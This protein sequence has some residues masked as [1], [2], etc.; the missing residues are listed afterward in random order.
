MQM[1]KKYW[2][3]MLDGDSADFR[4][5][6]N[7]YINLKDFRFGPTSDQG[8]AEQLE[9]VGGTQL[10]A[11]ANLPVGGT[12]YCIG[13]AEDY[14]NRRIV[15]FLWNSLGNHGIYCYDYVAAI[16]NPVLLSSQITGGLNFDKHHLIHSARVANNNVYWTDNVN[17]PRR[18]NID[19]GIN[20]N[21][22]VIPPVIGTYNLY[23][24]VP[25]GQN[26]SLGTLTVQ[27]YL[28]LPVNITY[29]PGVFAQ[30]TRVASFTTVFQ[31]NPNWSSFPGTP[32]QT[33]I[34][35]ALE[36]FL[37]GIAASSPATWILSI[38][39]TVISLTVSEGWDMGTGDFSLPSSMPLELYTL[40]NLYS[41]IPPVYMAPLDQ[42][43]IAWIRRQ[44]AQPPTQLKI[45]ESPVPSVNF[46]ADEAFEFAYR[47]QYIDSELSTLSGLS[48]LAD[49]N[50]QDPPPSITNLAVPNTSLTTAGY[51]A[52]NYILPTAPVPGYGPGVQAQLTRVGTAGP[53]A[54][55]TNIPIPLDWTNYPATQSYTSVIVNGL[56]NYF[57]A[58]PG[59]GSAGVLS[60]GPL[61]QSVP[62]SGK[63]YI[64]YRD[65]QHPTLNILQTWDWGLSDGAFP[66]T[67]TAELTLYISTPAP[68]KQFNRI[69]IS[70]PPTETIRQDVVQVDLVANFLVSGIYF[71][72]KSW[73][74]SLVADAIAIAYHNQGTTP[75]TY[76]FYNN[77]AGIA[78][79]STYAVKPYDSVPLV[80]STIEIAKSRG[81]LANYLAGYTTSNLTTSLRTAL[82][83]TVLGTPLGN[84]IQGEWFSVISYFGAG[85]QNIF[86]VIRT[87][88]AVELQPSSPSGYYYYTLLPVG[89]VPPFPV[90]ISTG[91]QYIG[92]DIFQTYTFFGQT[93]LFLWKPGPITD[94]G[95]S[96]AV[97]SL[98]QTLDFGVLS[99]AFKSNASYQLGVT[100]YD[101]YGRKGGIITNSTLLVNVPNTAFSANQY[102]TVLTWT[103]SNT[104]AATEIP[105]WAYYYSVDITKCLRTRFFVQS[106][107]FIIYAGKD[108]ENDYTFD[109]EIW[110]TDLAGVAI[111]LTFL[112]S[113]GMGYVFSKGDVVDFYL[114]GAYYS[115]SIIGQSA[116]YII[117]E[118]ADVGVLGSGAFGYY[119]I[120]TPYQPQTDEPY[121]EM[122]AIYPI[123]NPTTGSPTYGLLS[124]SMGGDVFVSQLQNAL[125]NYT[126]E[127]MSP[128]AKFYQ[129]WFTDAGRPNF[130]DYIGQVQRSTSVVWSD[131]YING[132]A[133]NGLSTFEAL[134]QMDLDPALGPVNKL[135]LTSKTSKIGVV[136]LAIC[137]GGSTAS[138]Y[139]S[140]NTLISDT[141]DSVVA[142]ANSV[143][144]SVHELKGDFGT[145]NP[146]SV[147]ELRGNVYW[148][149][150]QNGKIIQYADNG[151][152]PISNYKLSRFWKLFSDQYKS[153][154]VAEI[155]A[156][157]S[158]PYV[159][160]TADPHHGELM[161]SVPTVL[162]APPNGYLPD[163]PGTPYPFDIYDG[164]G[165]TII[166]KLYTDPNHWQGSYS[167]RPEYLCYLE[168]NVFSFVGG[169]L[170]LHNQPNYCNYY[171][172]QYSPSVMF[173]SNQEPSK[174]KSY[175]NFSAES[176]QLPA[177]IY[178]MTR[179][180]NLQSS[181]LY[182]IDFTTLEGLFYAPIYRN[183][184]DP[185]YLMDFPAAL[186][187]GEKMRG[188]ALY[189]WAQWAITNG[190][191]QV[192]YCNLGYTLSLGQKV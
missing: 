123:V 111:D 138:I 18:L 104:S 106:I 35:N 23:T 121:F 175:N 185:A 110:N 165:K 57:K 71:I 122:G 49:F 29:G 142:Q 107:G 172:V 14:P 125:N 55:A 103:L 87:T 65:G 82:T 33:I 116:Q 32:Y 97:L 90:S 171:G 50:E 137:G 102:A 190:I 69:D 108:S 53:N 2:T 13:T 68:S 179:Y 170:Y 124:G 115:L 109:T 7:A 163:Y 180:P 99:K 44:P 52:T 19:A 147:I 186:I 176:N 144:G 162:A 101:F 67:V 94:T 60:S 22:G 39:G 41:T 74:K 27:Y 149:D 168:D 150:A 95:Q 51:L 38:S 182:N 148:Y 62:Q 66:P 129:S 158:R 64:S 160:G 184:L 63:W 118:L 177:L 78:L 173:L 61:P 192:K 140:E 59:N 26:V 17:E 28:P 189:V 100:F 48:T 77:Q 178:L 188:T 6:Q 40:E 117:A 24:L 120:Y 128:N 70:I 183:K 83:M 159:F 139:L 45:M 127:S 25:Y 143:I 130:L 135:Q 75:L 12:T 164:I 34:F 72:I 80:A 30:L 96:S 43:I 81:F 98:N 88:R 31:L 141:G 10:I 79:D 16:I 155:E 3:D 152:F 56:N 86:Y 76:S 146:E 151:L 84:T 11:N 112:N 93:Q 161:W 133:D 1:E 174:P 47:Y 154:T 21:T 37:N 167:F 15:F 113:Q 9:S 54:V 126:A 85:E 119:E 181:D 145:L 105:A 58:L 8:F 131:T 153:L 46:I 42:S 132:T 136:M 89:T 4:V 157:G 5:M 187:A 156:L 92:T 91:L 169:N 36:S 134:D 166:Y 73:R 20:M 114:F 191:V